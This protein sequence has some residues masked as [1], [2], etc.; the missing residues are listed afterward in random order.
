MARTLLDLIQQAADEIGIPQPSAIIG[1]VDDQSR[2]LL[3][4]A[5]RGEGFFYHG[6][7]KRWV[8]ESS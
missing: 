2:Q 7:F 8:A 6:E 3:A 1:Q 4:L 5:N